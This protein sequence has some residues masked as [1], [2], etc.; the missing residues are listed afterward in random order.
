MEFE[1][2]NVT[3]AKAQML[4]TGN[5]NN[6]KVRPHWVKEL[7][8]RMLSG[9][10]HQTHQGILLANDGTLLD[11]QHRLMA[12]AETGVSITMPVFYTQDKESFKV[13]DQGQKRSINDVTGHSVKVVGPVKFFI[14]LLAGQHDPNNI[15]TVE[16]LLDSELG[17]NIV[18]VSE[19]TAKNTKSLSNAPMRAAAAI[20]AHWYPKSK[21]YIYNTFTDI[22]ELNFDKMPN[23]GK[24]LVRQ[25]YEN[26]TS[27]G[28]G[29]RQRHNFVRGC[30]VFD[31]SKKDN[32]SI[33]IV[34]STSEAIISK[35]KEDVKKVI[36]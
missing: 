24:S 16:N 4:L 31:P 1:M 8:R 26:N 23:V 20:S 33:R 5:V 9:D 34:Q 11:G 29:V 6:R 7:S 3:P 21:D 10:W 2:M 36:T 14:H 18:E 32:K 30:V 13:L 35:A 15:F 12:I 17:N 19:L 22:V 28:G 25:V 27:P